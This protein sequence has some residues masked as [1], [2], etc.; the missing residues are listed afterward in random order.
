MEIATLSP[1]IQKGGQ[2]TLQDI[3]SSESLYREPSVSKM[4]NGSSRSDLPAELI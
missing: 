3:F 1:T 2:D 4:Q